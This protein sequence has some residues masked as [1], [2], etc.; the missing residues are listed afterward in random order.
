MLKY[1][2]ISWTLSILIT[3]LYSRLEKCCTARLMDLPTAVYTNLNA[4]NSLTSIK[5]LKWLLFN[6]WRIR[7]QCVGLYFKHKAAFIIHFDCWS[8]IF[9]ILAFPSV[10][11]LCMRNFCEC[12]IFLNYRFCLFQICQ[13]FCHIFTSTWKCKPF[14]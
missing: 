1:N 3:V 9:S 4:A 6:I 7:Y 10:L 8:L 2:S 11:K 12:H 13:I 5:V 14:Q